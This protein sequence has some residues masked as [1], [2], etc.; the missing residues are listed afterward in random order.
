MSKDSPRVSLRDLNLISRDSMFLDQEALVQKEDQS[1]R[2]R[3]W[4]AQEFSDAYVRFRPHLIRQARSLLTSEAEAEEVVQDAFLYLMTALPELDSE[5]G[6]LRFLKWKTRM[7]CLDVVRSPKFKSTVSLDSCLDLPEGEATSVAPDIERAEDAAVIRMAL[8]KLS[9]RH[10]EIIIATHLQEKSRAELAQELGVTENALRQLLFR[11]RAAF[12]IALVGEA[13]TAGKTIS[14]ILSIAARKNGRKVVGLGASGLLMAAIL[15]PI[16]ATWFDEFPGPGTSLTSAQETYPEPTGNN[17]LASP[18]DGLTDDS[19]PSAKSL[20]DQGMA[21]FL[22][23]TATSEEIGETETE[24]TA[25]LGRPSALEEG[26]ITQLNQADRFR[27]ILNPMLLTSMANSARNTHAQLSGQLLELVSDEGLVAYVGLNT[28]SEAIVQ[29]ISIIYEFESEDG[30]ALLT[31]VP[32]TRM[33]VSEVD[34]ANNIIVHFAAT[35]LLW[36]DLNGLYEGVSLS[37]S[38]ISQ[39]GILIDLVLSDSGELRSATMEI[40]DRTRT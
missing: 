10:R 24:G 38:Q 3:D 6:V 32:M 40:V 23:A 31:A 33:S 34:E 28:D 17:I 1:L 36:G 4:T 35:D 7:L 18:S 25:V 13:D 26:E 11:A 9:A 8:A 39:S 27:Q 12:K 15:A 16:N 19:S 22:Y 30:R 37:D 20:D 5:L 29:H 21:E 2:L 14:E